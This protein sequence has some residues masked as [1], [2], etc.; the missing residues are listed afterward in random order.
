MPIRLGHFQQDF[1]QRDPDAEPVPSVAHGFVAMVSALLAPS[2]GSP[3]VQGTTG[4]HAR[5][6]T[7][8]VHPTRALMVSGCPDEPTPAG[9]LRPWKLAQRWALCRR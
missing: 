5:A 7:K 1:P 9:M 6:M 4:S 3:G 2:V 8:E